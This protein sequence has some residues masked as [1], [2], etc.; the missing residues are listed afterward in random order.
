MEGAG[1]YRKPLLFLGLAV[2]G[3]AAALIVA[4]DPIDLDDRPNIERVMKLAA[5]S[6]R[7]DLV[8]ELETRG[9]SLRRLARLGMLGSVP[10]AEWQAAARLYLTHHPGYLSL[11]LLDLAGVSRG[12]VAAST[13]RRLSPAGDAAVIAAL[14]RASLAHWTEDAPSVAAA[15]LSEGRHGWL[16]AV[17]S[18]V[19]GAPA[20]VLVVLLDLEQ[21]LDHIFSD[22]AQLGYAIAIR[23]GADEIYRSDRRRSAAGRRWS[24]TET[25]RLSGLE[26]QIAASP[27]PQLIAGL[28]S[29][30]PESAVV[31]ALALALLLT[32]TLHLARTTRVQAAGLRAARDELESR[33][34]ARTAELERTNE[35]LLAEVA[36][37][38]RMEALLGRLSARVLHVQDQERR[39]IARELHDGTAQLLSAVRMN[40]GR[41]R[42]LLPSEPSKVQSIVH[43]TEQLASQAAAEVRTISYLL[44]PATLDELGLASALRGYVAGFSERSGIEVSLEVREGVHRLPAELELTLFRIVQEALGNIDR[45]S[46]S[47]TAQISLTC[48]AAEARLTIRDQGRGLT[49]E[50]LYPERSTTPRVG[51]GITGMRERLRE[52]GGRLEIDSSDAGTT[53]EVV[54]PVAG[55]GAAS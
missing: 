1:R 13:E 49:E 7:A 52:L 39:R 24:Q 37:R 33:V 18:V 25:L 11:E 36:E 47:R 50:A 26:W 9:R 46:G 44:Y 32:S 12:T 48:C 55:T 43:D 14:S 30:V 2:L 35:R 21:T 51:I 10:D 45:H 54:L 31:V 4:V 8:A 28:R 16:L 34:A 42:R 5:S 53:I 40:F 41:L 19:E 6:A 17:P 29:R 22:H 20:G 23:Q 15:T 27:E 38:T 3:L